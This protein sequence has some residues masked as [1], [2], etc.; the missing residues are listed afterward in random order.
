MSRVTEGTSAILRGDGCAISSHSD[1]MKAERCRR[2]ADLL[3]QE[4]ALQ[5]QD[6]Y[7]PPDLSILPSFCPFN[8]SVATSTCRLA[9][10]SL[11]RFL[12]VF[13]A[14]AFRSYYGNPRADHLLT[15]A[16]LNVFRAFV[17]NIAVLG[18]SREWMTDDALSR[19]GISGPHPN[20]VP[21]T[22]IP[23]N[24]LIQHEDCMGD[25]QFCRHLM[26]FWTISSKEN[27]ML[28]WVNC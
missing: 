4:L 17:C 1:T 13:E 7:P 23:P 20:A 6:Q 10:P 19:F 12:A 9:H 8:T 21:V 5:E 15:L 27:C 28:V 18:Y 2:E 11:Y 22:N 26:G 16:K 3:A 24:N 25:S 14:A